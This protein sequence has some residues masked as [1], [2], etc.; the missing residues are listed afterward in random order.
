MTN[1][2]SAENVERANKAL[3]DGGFFSL[4]PNAMMVFSFT[5][6]I[7]QA[8]DA[9]ERRGAV[10]YLRA[11]AKKYRESAS[12]SERYWRMSDAIRLDQ[13]ANELEA[14]TKETEGEQGR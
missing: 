14:A 1:Q 4:F 13:L 9:A 5:A 10:K 8:L 3:V 11:T 12:A 7:A 2:P 6:T